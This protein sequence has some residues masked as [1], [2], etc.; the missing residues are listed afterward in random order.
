ME[1]N[2]PGLALKGLYTCDYA[3]LSG[4]DLSMHCA[5]T[6]IAE[7]QLRNIDWGLYWPLV[8]QRLRASLES[9]FDRTWRARRRIEGASRH[10]ARVH[11]PCF[12]LERRSLT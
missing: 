2:H 8:N 12:A 1:P 10:S 5:P 3:T 6:Q 9:L 11:S 4:D 7:E